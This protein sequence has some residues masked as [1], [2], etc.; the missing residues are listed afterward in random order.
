M[1]ERQRI[2]TYGI[3]T[4]AVA[5]IALAAWLRPW[6]TRLVDPD[7]QAPTVATHQVDIVFAVDTTASMGNLIEGAKRTVW[8]IATHVR[9]VDPQADLHV[10]LVAYRDV[11]DEY[12]TKDLPLTSDLDSVFAELSSYV[13]DGGGDPP[14]DVD[15][16][17]Y[18][19]VHRMT[20]RAD[21]KK[22]IF[23]VGDEPPASRGDVPRYDV[24]VRDAAEQ[25]IKV[26]A[27]RCGSLAQTAEV[28]QEI[29]T[30]GH[31]EF[32]TIEHD[33][34]VQQVA[35]P[36]DRKMAEL[37]SRIDATTVIY[38]DAAV[39][40]AYDGKMAAAAAAPEATKADRASYFAKPA[41]KGRGREADDI[42]AG[43]GSGAVDIGSLDE[44]KLP[45]GMQGMSKDA[46][47]KELARRAD[48]RAA[49]QKELTELAKKRAAY[50][51]DHA[52]AK[53]GFDKA[54]D[55]TVEDELK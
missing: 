40:A 49:A 37:S 7:P 41:A 18:D 27:I 6:S 31:G 43:Y 26:N 13:A 11:G 15:A 21:A 5:A 17:L 46:L 35:T 50:L 55:Q 54:V 47:A 38:G 14:E 52:G 23:L 36:Y 9:E 3:S 25:H 44:G 32:S 45:A 2:V 8:S 16:A 24:S 19:A 39:Q 33:G 53:S 29:A 28:W 30:L 48:E 12:V 42:V 20:W 34:G 10:G 4:A 51:H 22:L 1:V